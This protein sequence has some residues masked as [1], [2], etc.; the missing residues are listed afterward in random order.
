MQGG[1]G[2]MDR[3]NKVTGGFAV[4]GCVKRLYSPSLTA[5]SIG[6]HYRTL[7]M[8]TVFLTNN[9]ELVFT[10]W[11]AWSITWELPVTRC[12][13]ISS[14]GAK[15][16][17][18]QGLELVVH[19]LWGWASTSNKAEQLKGCA[20]LEQ[21]NLRGVNLSVDSFSWQ[22][23]K[24]NLIDSWETGWNLKIHRESWGSAHISS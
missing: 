12:L 11:L 22:W 20:D 17:F 15:G 7:R 10:V 8:S 24:D 2:H 19:V 14:A 3:K 1:H 13:C 18:Y 5:L 23:S 9:L 6:G 21:T 4:C 16:C